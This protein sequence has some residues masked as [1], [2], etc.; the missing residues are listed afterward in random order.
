LEAVR[1]PEAIF[2]LASFLGQ[3]LVLHWQ[4][5]G[6][7]QHWQWVPQ[8]WQSGVFLN[9]VPDTQFQNCFERTVSK[10]APSP[11]HHQISF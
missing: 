7:T 4:Y 11:L 5:S 8:H 1:I 6:V 10:H 9:V 3:R 2:W